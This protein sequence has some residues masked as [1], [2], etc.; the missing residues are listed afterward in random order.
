MSNVVQLFKN[1]T[2]EEVEIQIVSNLKEMH[3]CKPVNFFCAIKGISDHELG[4]KVLNVLI[5]KNVVRIQQLRHRDRFG[6]SSYASLYQYDIL[7]PL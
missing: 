6:K 1:M 2:L 4:H 5:A 7:A 3:H